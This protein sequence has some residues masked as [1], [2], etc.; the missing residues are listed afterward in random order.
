MSRVFTEQWA[1]DVQ[2][3][4]S[5][6]FTE[7]DREGRLPDYG[8]WVDTASSTF[9]GVLALGAVPVKE[10]DLDAGEFVAIR[11]RKAWCRRFV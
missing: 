3:H 8:T 5:Q 1:A 6:G 9:S 11:S 4:L 7:Q 2:A 10:D